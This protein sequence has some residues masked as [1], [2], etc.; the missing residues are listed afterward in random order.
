MKNPQY[1]SKKNNIMKYK[2]FFLVLL[3]ISTI[4]NAQNYKPTDDGSKVHFVI[5]NF[6]IN[7]GGDFNGL[8]GN[9]I[10]TPDSPSSCTFNV[11]VASNTIDTDNTLRDKSLK[12]AEYLNTENY[13]EIQLISTKIDKTNKTT[14]GYYYF[15]GKIIM[16]GI[17]KQ[18]SFPFHADKT[19][20]GYLFTGNFEINRV[21]FGVGEK[22]AVLGNKVIVSLKILAKKK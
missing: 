12:S 14:S 16:H 7:T 5:K 11:S 21:D 4:T 3:F 17:T 8:K 2:Y 9:I 15:T 22:S 19:K 6:G 10:F 13:P 20:D 1:L 18:I